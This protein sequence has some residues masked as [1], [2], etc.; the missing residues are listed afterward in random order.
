LVIEVK[1]PT[2]KFGVTP[3]A[4]LTRRHVIL[5]CISINRERGSTMNLTRAQEQIVAWRLGRYAQI[6]RVKEDL[7]ALKRGR[8][9]SSGLGGLGVESARNGE[10]HERWL[11]TLVW[12]LVT[13]PRVGQV[14]RARTKST[15]VP[16]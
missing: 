3:Y 6:E 14:V 7:C 9:P 11:A 10:G 4:Y 16:T 8:L 12:R 2:P 15:V 13:R 1:S 5:S